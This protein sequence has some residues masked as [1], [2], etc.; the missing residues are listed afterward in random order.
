MSKFEGPS[1]FQFWAKLKRGEVSI[2]P[3]QQLVEAA[4]RAEKVEIEAAKQKKKPIS[5]KKEK[6]Q[7]SDKEGSS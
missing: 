5:S 3:S 2:K 1:I 7:K 4:G 6:K